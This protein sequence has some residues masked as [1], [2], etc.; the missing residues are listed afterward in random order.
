MCWVNA[1][2][3]GR[4]NGDLFPDPEARVRDPPIDPTR[5]PE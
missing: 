5:G 4:A 2:T 3:T 1:S